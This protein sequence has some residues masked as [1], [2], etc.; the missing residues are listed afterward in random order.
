MEEDVNKQPRT[1]IDNKSKQVVVN[2]F[3]YVI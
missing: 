1:F 2:T 3:F